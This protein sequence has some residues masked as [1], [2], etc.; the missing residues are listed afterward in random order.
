MNDIT[1]TFL[2]GEKKL[3]PVEYRIVKQITNEQYLYFFNYKRVEYFIET[4]FSKLGPFETKDEIFNM[5][6]SGGF[7]REL[8]DCTNEQQA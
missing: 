5:A 7:W 4:D 8:K 2:T 1:I 6:V 3:E